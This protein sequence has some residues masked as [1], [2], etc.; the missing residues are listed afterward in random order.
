MADEEDDE[1]IGVFCSPIEWLKEP[2]VPD[3]IVMQCTQCETM[4]WVAPSS[5]HISLTEKIPL[6][7]MKHLPQLTNK[8]QLL[9]HPLQDEEV[10]QGIKDALYAEPE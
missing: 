9:I 7:C 10:M 6:L 4:M 2:A 8:D 5:I 3:A 1:I